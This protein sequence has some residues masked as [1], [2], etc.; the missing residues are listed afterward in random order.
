MTKGERPIHRPNQSCHSATP[1]PSTA[2]AMERAAKVSTTAS[3][4]V[5]PASTA[6]GGSAE[7]R[8][9][10]PRRRRASWSRARERQPGRN[11]SPVPTRPRRGRHGD[12]RE[13]WRARRGRWADIHHKIRRACSHQDARRLLRRVDLEWGCLHIHLTLSKLP[14]RRPGLTL[15]I[16]RDRLKL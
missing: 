12:R 11:T 6:S 13:H 3:E 5:N 2:S 4:A 8:S 15:P 9:V 10:R 7:A 1:V 14:R 16:K